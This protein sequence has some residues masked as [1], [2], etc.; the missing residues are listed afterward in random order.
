[1]WVLQR[2]ACMQM[3]PKC[4]CVWCAIL[5]MASYYNKIRL[6]TEDGRTELKEYE[7]AEQR[8]SAT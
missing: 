3:E 1:M 7:V 6:R 2:V 5:I 8:V 4:V